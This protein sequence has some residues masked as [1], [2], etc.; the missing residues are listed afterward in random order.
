MKFKR[1]IIFAGGGILLA[2]A[3]IYCVIQ[4]WISTQLN[5]FVENLLINGVRKSTDSLYFVSYKK[6]SVNIAERAIVLL[7]VDVQIDTSIYQ[8]RKSDSLHVPAQLF[9]IRFDKL[10]ITGISVYEA[11]QNKNLVFK[12]FII[13]NPMVDLIISEHIQK[14]D[15]ISKK[16]VDLDLYKLFSEKFHSFNAEKII[17]T[18]G[19]FRLFKNSTDTIPIVNSSGIQVE[20]NKLKI[21][22]AYS[23]NRY[24]INLASKI[25]ISIA[26]AQWLLPDSIYKFQFSKMYLD[27]ISQSL[28][29]GKIQ[30]IPLIK[31]YKLAAITGYQ[32]DLIDFAAQSLHLKKLD[33][34]RLIY[35]K[36]I[37][38]RSATLS[39][40]NLKSFRYKNGKLKIEKKLLP[41]EQ[42]KEAPLLVRIDSVILKNG[43][44]EYAEQ[45]PGTQLA[46]KVSFSEL[47]GVVLNLTNDSLTL[48]KNSS[49]DFNA[50]CLLMNK[51]LL[52][53]KMQFN[54]L[55]ST[56]TFSFSGTLGSMDMTC[57]NPMI[58]QTIDAE[59]KQGTIDKITFTADGNK[60]SASGTMIFLYHDFS[61][62]FPPTEENKNKMKMKIA[63]SFTNK[64]LL[65]TANPENG[66]TRQTDL[67]AERDEN[68]YLFNYF[69]KILFSGIK[70]SLVSEK[71]KSGKQT[72]EDA[73]TKMKNLL[74]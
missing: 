30:L 70:E 66:I 5:P 54:Q 57:F 16:P 3:I 34:N 31:K 11:I 52:K 64:N 74:K 53:V 18:G 61:I 48:V 23:N 67:F 22:S 10:K 42:L 33:M 4:F 47:N 44:I 59:I 27:A 1:I 63:T 20:V 14:Q 43:K 58:Q 36:S 17:V 32:S 7:D 41:V 2:L 13:E 38:C 6:L 60:K 72:V 25:K 56:N 69:W 51:G 37:I 26:E 35:N 19:K 24:T 15:T 40:F 21:D 12:D 46:G 71:F 39:D 55:D 50:E 8:T 65:N 29:F 45:N 9:H 49:C 73:S 62:L 68:K 28:S